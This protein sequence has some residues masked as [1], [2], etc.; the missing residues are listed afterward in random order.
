MNEPSAFHQTNH[1]FA[2]A[3]QKFAPAV[4]RKWQQLLAL[5]PGIAELRRK[6]ASYRTITDILCAANVPVSHTTVV[7]FCRSVL[8]PSRPRKQRR[9]SP[10]PAGPHAGTGGPRIANPQTI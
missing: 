7:R 9:P 6:G 5:R 3:V 1:E 8:Q 2:E 4:P 10:A